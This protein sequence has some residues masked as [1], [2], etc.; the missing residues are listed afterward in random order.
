MNGGRG[1]FNSTPFGNFTNDIACCGGR[2]GAAH[3]ETAPLVFTVKD[4]AGL[5]VA[6]VGY[7]VNGANQV[8]TFGT[9][10]H[11]L[12]STG[13]SV[14]DLTTHA[15]VPFLFAADIFDKKTGL[16]Y[17]V[18]ARY[19]ERV[20]ATVPEPGVWT[21]MTL[22]FGGLGAMLRRRRAMAVIATA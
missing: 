9:G 18:A 13:S 3:G 12:G 22:G 20:S 7:T 10:D 14:L 2:N 11:F 15:P 5:T 21:M 6:G 16:T 19:F 17:N 1:T 4:A 8:V